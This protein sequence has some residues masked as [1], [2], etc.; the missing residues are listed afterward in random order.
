MRRKSGVT[1]PLVRTK[2][3]QPPVPENLTPRPRLIERLN[4]A[5]TRPLT[6]I[7]AP[8]GFG[9][10]TLLSAWLQQWSQP[11]AWL[12]L[13]K[14]DNDLHHFLAYVLAAIRSVAPEMGTAT[15][16]LLDGLVLPPTAV[17]VANLINDLDTI[18]QDFVLV[19]DDYYYISNRDIHN[20][21][22]ALLQHPPRLMHLVIATRHDPLLPR[23]SLL[24][25][26]K[27]VEIRA[28]ELAL[29]L[30]ETAVYLQ[31]TLPTPPDPAIVSV[32]HI[33]TEGWITGLRLTVLSLPFQ[34]DVDTLAAHFQA[35]NRMTMDYLVAE[36][37]AQQPPEFQTALLQT[38]V[39]DRFSRELCTAVCWPTGISGAADSG[40][41]GQK[42]I[43]WLEEMNLFLVPL[44]EE[45][46]WFR[47]HHL[48]KDLLLHQLRQ[49]Y[50]PEQ[51]NVLH[52]R[53]SRWFAQH[54]LP[55]EAIQH[56]LAAHD[57]GLAVE[58]VAEHRQ[59]QMN[60]E[61]WPLL[62]QWLRL[63]PP[64]LV[65]G[66]PELLLLRAWILYSQWRYADLP[67]ILERLE[68][69]LAHAPEATAVRLSGEV[70]ALRSQQFFW[71]HQ[72]AQGV[73]GSQRALAQLPADHS[74]VRGVAWVF[75]AG[76][77]Y[78]VGD[79]ATAI[80]QT[81]QALAAEQGLHESLAARLLTALAF[82]HL[83][84]ANM[85]DL[86]ATANRLLWL[87]EDRGLVE[88]IGSARY[89]LGAAAYCQDHLAAA[90]SHFLEA[91]RRRYVVHGHAYAQS[92]FGL[93]LTYQAQGHLA[94]AAAMAAE[95][96]TFWAEMKN[97][98][99]HV[100]AQTFQAHLALMAGD[101]AVALSWLDRVTPPPQ[102]TP[103]LEFYTPEMTWG[104][105]LLM[106]GKWAEAE[107]Y[108]GRLQ[109]FLE[110]THNTRF[111]VETLAQR[112]W[113]FQGQG[114]QD[115]A[116]AT[117]K[118]ALTLAAPSHLV[119]PLA[120]Y[121][122]PLHPLWDQLARQRFMPDYLARIQVV[123]GFPA[124][125]APVGIALPANGNSPLVEPLTNRE[126]DVLL[127]MEKRLTNKE[128]AQ[129]LCISVVTV[130]RHTYNLYQKLGVHGR[131]QA[132]NEARKL[133]V[134]V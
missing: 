95:V 59:H 102:L 42:F 66:E 116:V 98:S 87:A 82:L 78:L 127:L 61:Q 49:R 53:A 40:E 133:G 44:D 131:R 124:Q 35:N 16:A 118:Q 10:S 30:A 18:T 47:F 57:T 29:T 52:G 81:Q 17:L 105:A 130:K 67:P 39:L 28:P 74:Y 97:T 115:T 77:R 25:Q 117:L 5:G 75:L 27:M 31:Q 103:M 50:S 41:R 60:R 3:Y 8:A 11:T 79:I 4:Q 2:F 48:F 23:A 21:M 85:P 80:T 54:N 125:P 55:I 32:L 123:S 129:E 91:V 99:Q 14:S 101:T 34:A 93:A 33:K 76:N 120:D 43:A 9:K 64:E 6:L 58:I 119:R 20:I 109:P 106:Q 126:M 84:A 122:D 26:G 107:A 38:S 90:E 51:M 72:A 88:S 24:A 73:E 132:V 68:S 100:K 36:A 45:Q 7:S 128:I 110:S 121:A 94:E 69:L 22:A 134:I 65:D 83:A 71:T 92:G 13:D 89:F 46:E 114:K 15:Q 70:A 56:A 1:A 104:R 12:S 86:T 112:A 37:L 62:N 111:L 96:T 108:L 19:L 113:L 63:F